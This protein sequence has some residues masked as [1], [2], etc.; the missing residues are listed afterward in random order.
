[1][2]RTPLLRAFRALADD[3]RAGEALGLPPAEAR[4]LRA[5][6]LSRREFLRRAGAVGAGA[7]LVP[8]A[9]ARQA[10]SATAPR[11]A[12]VGG[13]IAGLTAA[14][15]LADKGYTSTVYEASTRVGGR[16]HSDMSTYFG[17]QTAE[18]C[19]ELIDTGHTTIR[20]LAQ[21][22]GLATVDLLAA[23]PNGTEDTYWFL[24]GYYT[25]EQADKDFQPIH[26]TLQ[27]QVQQTGYPTT[28]L[29]HTDAGVR[30]DQMS[31]YEWIERYAGG[32]SSRMG[33]LLDVAYNIEYGA[34][35]KDQAALNLMYLLG[36]NA[37]P[38]NF[39]IFGASDERFHIVG[40][41]ERLPLAIASYLGGDSTIKR[42][43][44][45]QSIRTNADG[46][47]SLE[48]ATPGKTQTV[49]ADHVILTLPFAVLRTLDYSGAGF[50]RLKKTAITQLGAGKNAKLQ[51]QFTTR[52][53]NAKR[54]NGNVYTD[55]GLQSAW[56]VTRGQSGAAGILVDY[57]GG[58]V[59]GGYKPSTPY[60][61]ASTNPQVT[62][63]AR[64]FLTQLEVVFPGISGQ[65]NGRAS[66]S[67]PFLD[68]N[69]NLA[70]SYWRCGQ[71]TSFGGYEG[72]A[73]GNVHFAGEHTS[74]DFQGYM[75]GGASEGA[76]A[77]SE[78]LAALKK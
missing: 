38:G 72:A 69:L 30:F 62:A 50:D 70:Y 26:Q 7:V 24:N 66:L 36:Y 67:T 58:N 14:L 10:T 53:W 68:P 18:Y 12:I 29:A 74:Q 15:T 54:S 4:G 57:S 71:Y 23:E 76:R 46:T 32:H 22:F 13:G 56:D 51:L 40:G 52:Y 28:Y 55:V 9:L 8:G 65:W 31:V 21:R 49:T 16:M 27:G 77:A 41:N 48:F 60:S 1:M 44:A 11:I 59:A 37:Q 3:H 78:V 35:T 47:V 45:M 6:A 17:G 64:Q 61:N 73:Q 34:E 33:R 20:H 19:G 43:W 2:A 5:E 75:E 42:G 39:L 25:K 63:Y